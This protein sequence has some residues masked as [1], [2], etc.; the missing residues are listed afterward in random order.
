MK[1]Y[2]KATSAYDCMWLVI[3]SVMF[4]VNV[5]KGDVTG[6]LL[7]ASLFL[8]RVSDII[9]KVDLVEQKQ[10]LAET[11]TMIFITKLADKMTADELTEYSK[12]ISEEIQKRES[13]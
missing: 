12:E 8:W 10:K 1:K 9:S 4:G 3:H 11:L 13:L 6:M 5:S 7:W 2:I